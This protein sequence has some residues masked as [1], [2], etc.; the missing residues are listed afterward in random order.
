MADEL[1]IDAGLN[2]ADFAVIGAGN[3]GMAMAGFL[4]LRGYAVNLWNRSAKPIHDIQTCG[5]I[6]LEGEIRGV[7]VP[8]NVTTNIEDV[9]AGVPVI[10]VTV[11]ASGHETVARLMAPHLGDGQIVVLNP[12]RTGGALAFR[13]TLWKEGCSSSVTVAETNTFIYAARTVSSGRSR[14]FGVKQSVSVAALP[15]VRTVQVVRALRPAF[16]QFHAVES[17]MVTSLDNMGAVFHPVPTL[18]NAARI[19]ASAAFEHYTDGI[20]P[21]VASVLE[22]LDAERMSIASAL[23]VPARSAL[24]WLRETYGIQAAS[25]YD[26]IQANKAYHGISAP[27]S[28]NCRYITEDVPFS[29]VPMLSLAEVA[30]VKAPVIRAAVNFASVLTGE[31]YMAEG[32]N[33]A[34]MGIGGMA[35]EELAEHVAAEVWQG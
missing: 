6:L 24:D 25:L 17:V 12:G 3:G 21:S 10:M 2:R 20:S 33:A 34:S 29:L 1:R 14:V 23:G 11:P 31:D 13:A 28:L 26:A 4:A 27:T 16:P 5:G 9:V 30:G 35:G 8:N 18:L 22:A 19:D 15:A 7:A 32:R